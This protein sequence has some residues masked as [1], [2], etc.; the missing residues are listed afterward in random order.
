MSGIARNASV[1][2]DL[3]ESNMLDLSGIEAGRHGADP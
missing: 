2:L 1:M 3:V